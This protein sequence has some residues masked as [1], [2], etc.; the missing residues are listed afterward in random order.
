M[1]KHHWMRVVVP[2]LGVI[3]LLSPVAQSSKKTANTKPNSASSHAA[4]RP[5]QGYAE[6]SS[7]RLR[8][9]SMPLAFEP[10]APRSSASGTGAQFVAHGARMDIAL[11]RQGIELAPRAGTRTNSRV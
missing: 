4:T 11:A 3:A 7:R 6:G 1:A 9:F 2:C 5:A 10:E 8:P